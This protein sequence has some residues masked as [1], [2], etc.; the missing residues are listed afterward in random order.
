MP[1]QERRWKSRYQW[2][3]LI[4]KEHSSDWYQSTQGAKKSLSAHVQTHV[5]DGLAGYLVQRL[6]V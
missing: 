5:A 2:Q 6:D 4:C 3:C 1:S